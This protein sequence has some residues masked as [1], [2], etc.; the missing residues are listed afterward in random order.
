MRLKCIQTYKYIEDH[1]R[2]AGPKHRLPQP[3]KYFEYSQSVWI[4]DTEGS[5]K[6]I[7]VMTTG[8]NWCGGMKPGMWLPFRWQQVNIWQLKRGHSIRGLL[9]DE[10]M[11]KSAYAPYIW[12]AALYSGISAAR[13]RKGTSGSRWSLRGAIPV[14]CKYAHCSAEALAE[15]H[16]QPQLGALLP[17]LPRCISCVRAGKKGQ[18]SSALKLSGAPPPG[19]PKW[20]CPP[21]LPFTLWFTSCSGFPAAVVHFVED[22]VK[23]KGGRG[24][25]IV[26]SPLLQS[27][28]KALLEL[29]EA[30]MSRVTTVFV[31]LK[32]CFVMPS[33]NST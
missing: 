29:Q 18:W 32:Q 28:S 14:L 7:L 11:R 15:A 23:L 26:L 1:Q 17:F 3:Y 24:N 9:W 8:W 16:P 20:F 25:G 27:K 10:R 13:T 5:L 33:N 31:V 6:L 19:H 2:F 21:I 30:E 4:S 22:S 12:N